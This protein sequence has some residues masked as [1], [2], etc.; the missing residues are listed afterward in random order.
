MKDTGRLNAVS[1][2]PRQKPQS[3]KFLLLVATVC[4]VLNFGCNNPSDRMQILVGGFSAIHQELGELRDILPELMQVD[5]IVG[6]LA[7][8]RYKELPDKVIFLDGKTYRY[9]DVLEKRNGKSKVQLERLQ[10]LSRRVGLSAI[11]LAVDG[12]TV[13]ITM[14]MGRDHDWGY[15]FAID[16]KDL[17]H[18]TD[19][20]VPIPGEENWYVFQQ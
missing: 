10:K 2:A 5:G 12:Q 7:G 8:S 11:R 20:I 19:R 4:V 16:P 6:I 14:Y 13:W 3:S 15:V 9:S 18:E 1:R 17:L